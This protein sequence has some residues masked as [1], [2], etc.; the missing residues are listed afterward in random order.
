M[1]VR[2]VSSGRARW[3]SRHLLPAM[4]GADD[5]LPDELFVA[6]LFEL[7]PR[8]RLAAAL[9]CRRWNAVLA[10]NAWHQHVF[11][12]H[13]EPFVGMSPL[14][15]T[16]FVHDHV[17][18]AP[19]PCE[20]N[21]AYIAAFEGGDY[22]TMLRLLWPHRRVNHTG[23]WRGLYGAHGWE[24]VSVTQH[25]FDLHAVKLTG[26]PNVPAGQETF[27][28]RLQ[29]DLRFGG[30]TIQLAD[31]GFVNPRRGPANMRLSD[32]SA[33]LWWLLNAFLVVPTEL[34]RCQTPLA[35]VVQLLMRLPI[36]RLGNILNAAL[37]D[38]P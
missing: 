28:M 3:L 36:D 19:P 6:V 30:G 9:V 4:D 38:I 27:H 11:R 8:D 23:V 21:D 32:D 13:F 33:T 7:D 37:L 29:C 25:G 22:V 1:C 17:P 18:D 2:C 12:R 34:V 24:Y 20:Q 16:L 26:D 14:H 35:V 10:S 31:H 15:E 5:A